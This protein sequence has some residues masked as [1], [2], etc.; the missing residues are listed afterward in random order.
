[1]VF[2]FSDEHR[3]PTKSRLNAPI[4]ALCEILKN[5]MTSV[6]ETKTVI[7]FINSWKYISINCTI[8]FLGHLQLGT[9]MQVDRTIATGFLK[10]SIKQKFSKFIDMIFY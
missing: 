2:F 1:M 3:Q 5:S 8:D 9:S 4:H 7:A 10:K 6:V